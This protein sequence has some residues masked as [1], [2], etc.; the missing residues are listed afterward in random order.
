MKNI[1]SLFFDDNKYRYKIYSITNLRILSFEIYKLFFLCLYI[2]ILNK[3]S[4][5]FFFNFFGEINFTFYSYIKIFA[6]L[7]V[8]DI[9]YLIIF[10]LNKGIKS[11]FEML[12]DSIL[13]PNVI[14]LVSTSLCFILILFCT[15]E[16]KFLMPRL[17]YEYI[18]QKYHF[19]QIDDDY[20]DMDGYDDEKYYSDTFYII[21]IT[22]FLFLYMIFD[23]TKFDF[24][25]KV[26][27]TRINNLKKYLCIS[28]NNI[29]I[30]GVPA[31]FVI[32]CLNIFFYKTLSIFDLSINYT[33]LFVLEYNIFFINFNC[34]QNFICA[35]INF[36]AGDVNSVEKL[37]KK[38]IRFLKEDNFYIGHHLQHLRDLYEYPRDIKY[39]TNLLLYENLINLQKKINFFF[40]AINKKYSYSYNKRNYFYI[41][42]NS[43]FIDKT[44]NFLENIFSFFDFSANQ[45]IQKETCIQNMILLIEILGNVIN[46]IA[47]AK[48]NNKSNEEKY[49][50][51]KDYSYYFVDK[52]IDI[53]TIL[54]NLIQNKRIS[55]NLKNNLKKLRYIIKNNYELIRY[56]QMKNNFLKL[57]SQKLD[58]MIN[59]NHRY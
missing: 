1:N 19:Q 54:V 36:L 48:I 55:S 44:K 51:Y 28:L 53:D 29:G 2:F 43:D 14:K 42:Q 45:I 35:P 27:L 59:G 25:P 16:I 58:S 47:D 34:L 31:F 23:L 11:F 8:I 21:C 32:Y 15:K 4:H 57:M 50:E 5:L 7:L 49:E 18:K 41:N 33:F 40:E 20:I 56:K 12:I 39:N 24:W 17:E 6:Y 52:L 37:I 10:K 13:N 26:N 38:E 46:F 22:C 3:L 9:C 30:I